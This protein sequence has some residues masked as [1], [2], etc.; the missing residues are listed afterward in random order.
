MK[1][2]KMGWND[3]GQYLIDVYIDFCSV[4]T[5]IEINSSTEAVEFAF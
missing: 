3:V 2:Y 1:R 4:H 5:Q